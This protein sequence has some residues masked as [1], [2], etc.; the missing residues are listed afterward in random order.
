MLFKV[1]DLVIGMRVRPFEELEGLD[2]HELGM[3]AYSDPL[4]E[5]EIGKP[6]AGS[7][8]TLVQGRISVGK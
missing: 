2:Y 8:P 5:G 1:I 6:N 7:N 3:P 4:L